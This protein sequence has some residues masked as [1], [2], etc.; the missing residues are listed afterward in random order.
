MSGPSNKPLIAAIV[1]GAA[2]L[3]VAILAIAGVFSGEDDSGP[4]QGDDF[5]ITVP[6]PPKPPPEP[7]AETI[8]VGQARPDS[9]AAGAGHVW[10]TDSFSGKLIR[11]NPRGNAV[12]EQQAAGFPTDVTAGE[13]AAWLALPD[14]GAVQRVAPSGAAAEP[15]RVKDFPFQIS[16]G[17]G[18]VWAMSQS[19]IER[20]DPAD[21][22]PTDPPT[23]LEGPGSDVAAGEGWVWVTRGNREVVRISPDDGELSDTAAELPGAFNLTV[24]EGAVWALG[25]PPP[26]PGSTP[27]TASLIRVDPDSGET[28]GDPVRIPQALDVAAGLGYV[29]VSS[30]DGTVRRVDPD[31]GSFV[32]DPLDIGRVAQSIA[33]GEGAVWVADPAARAIVRI[34]P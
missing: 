31:T 32:G 15:E 10:A 28:A 16:A 24:G 6:E 2:V 22:T 20:V 21:G 3:I 7:T 9:I 33:V 26:A 5:G 30:A 11:V 8:R 13:G 18:A 27:A 19:S 12:R 29:W 34:E 23:K 4:S 1:A 14:R 25:A 17:E